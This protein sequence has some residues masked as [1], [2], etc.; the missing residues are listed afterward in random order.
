MNALNLI[1]F[2]RNDFPTDICI[3]LPKSTILPSVHQLLD[4]GNTDIMNG[5]RLRT[6]PAGGG[7][8]FCQKDLHS[9]ICLHF[10]K[11]GQ[12]ANHNISPYDHK[13]V[14]KVAAATEERGG[15]L[16]DDKFWRNLIH[17]I[18]DEMYEEELG[19][20]THLVDS[21]NS[22]IRTLF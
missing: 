7:V 22:H 14:G 20:F 10:V 18:L 3:F 16:D 4:V 15:R 1:N 8:A 13:S 21:Q 5:K 11:N 6:D 2:M 9:Q 19:V 17:L 12:I